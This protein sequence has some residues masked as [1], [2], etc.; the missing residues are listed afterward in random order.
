MLVGMVMNW[1]R[2]KM[3]A[4]NYTWKTVLLHQKLVIFGRQMNNMYSNMP[5]SFFIFPGVVSSQENCLPSASFLAASLFVILQSHLR[6]AASKT[7]SPG[8]IKRGLDTSAS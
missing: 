3:V 7:I 6:S 5:M 4:G 2:G 1:S 8:G